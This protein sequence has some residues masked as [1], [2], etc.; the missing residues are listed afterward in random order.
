[1]RK[2]FSFFAIVVIASSVFAREANTASWEI[3]KDALAT[4]L[5]GEG[6]GGVFDTIMRGTIPYTIRCIHPW[7]GFA[8]KTSVT[9]GGP[10]FHNSSEAKGDN[11]VEV[12]VPGGVKG[13]LAVTYATGSGSNSYNFFVNI[14]NADDEVPATMYDTV[15]VE[16]TKIQSFTT[17]KSK[18]IVLDTLDVNF[19]EDFEDKVLRI[20]HVSSTGGRFH[21]V[22]WIESEVNPNP[23]TALVEAKKAVP[24]RKMMVNGQMVI[25]RDGVQYNAIGTK[26]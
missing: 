14:A 3:K 13:R 25:V 4:K 8:I 19:Y 6:H 10:Y 5:I 21:N 23:P 11:Y 15:N 9:D 17:S 12:Y 20:F 1:M 18:T 16:S 2:M 26:L 24:A 22:T 7:D